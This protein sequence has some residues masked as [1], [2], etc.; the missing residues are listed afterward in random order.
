MKPIQ[1]L[2]VLCLIIL[3]FTTCNNKRIRFTYY[4]D[5]KQIKEKFEYF[6]VADT[7]T[8]EYTAFYSN[9]QI[10]NKGIV[11]KSIKEDVWQEWYEDGVFRG[12][13]YY[14]KINQPDKSNENRKLPEVILCADKLKPN[15]KVVVKVINLYP[16]EHIFSAGC[17]FIRLN[18][19]NYYDY[20]LI[21][22]DEDTAILFYA[23]PFLYDEIDM[24]WVKASEIAFPGEYAMMEKQL[25]EI[26]NNFQDQEVLTTKRNAKM[27]ELLKIPIEK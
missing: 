25:M 24:T 3:S 21:P 22:S 19:N 13:F 27:I 18:N 1:Q 11:R 4:E 9:G 14:N 16:N 17:N 23:H 2:A 26:N 5:S 15:A 6:T 10:K 12:E 7:S 8:Y 20:L